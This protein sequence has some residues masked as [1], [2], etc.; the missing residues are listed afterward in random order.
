LLENSLICRQPMSGNESNLHVG[1]DI[2]SLYRANK[3]KTNE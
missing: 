3:C 2:G 1:G